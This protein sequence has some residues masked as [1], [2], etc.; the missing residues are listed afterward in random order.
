MPSL[1]PN[2][3]QI[4]A[5][6]AI[7]GRRTQYR[8]NGCKGLVLD[9]RESGQRTWFV[10]YQPGGR[11]KRKFRW[12]KIGD[13]SAISLSDASEKAEAIVRAVQKDDRDPQAER[14][15]NRQEAKTFGDLFE[16]WHER[17][18]VPTLKR[19]DIDRM[20]Y[21]RHIEPGFAKT[22]VADL[23]R[24]EIGRF[25][26][27]VAKVATPLTSNSVLVLINRVL[28]WAV[29]EGLIEVNPAARLRKVGERRPRER[30]LS[31]AGI[32][33]FWQALDAMDTMT[34]EHMA[35]AEKGRMLSPATRSILRLLLL[36][37]QRRSEVVE[38]QKSELELDG[39]EPVWTIPGVRTKNGL[40]HRLPL[41]P[42]AAD[43]FRRA[44]KASP[45]ESSLVFPSPE[46]SMSP[47]SAA[48]VTRA[49]A[50]M[51]AEI[52]L[53]RVSPHD[54]RRTVGTELA[55]LGLP[56]HVRSLVLNHSPMSRG[57]TDAVYNRY[58][59]DKEK[60][61]ALGAWE[62]ELTRLLTR[63]FETVREAAE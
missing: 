44:V 10:R 16:D 14:K 41:C 11:G 6:K 36:T 50:R 1:K 17:Y 4:L 9:V 23:K 58:A 63:S 52:K 24:I 42:L 62:K 20:L 29:D 21:R 48:A 28:N 39:K 15:K 22:R 12:F 31:H 5:A 57:I 45:K 53:P 32:V 55:R 60:R 33:I 38:A 43:E 26:D 49:M 40:L 54:L 47:I 34:G 2:H 13:A 51:I 27:K 61:E 18:A 56:V 46:D 19:S 3:R 35:R 25:R 7:G 30:V 59:Y 37:G 8:I